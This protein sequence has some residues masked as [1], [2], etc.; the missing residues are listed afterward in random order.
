MDTIGSRARAYRN[1]VVVVVL[2]GFSLLIWAIVAWSISSLS[3]FILLLPVCSFYFLMDDRLLNRWRSCLL[4]DWVAANLELRYFRD[5]INAN[6]L[7]PKET[8]QGMLETL[9]A[10]GDVTDQGIL[11]DTREAI[12]GFVSF[13][14]VCRTDAIAFRTAGYA[15]AGC[16]LVIAAMLHSWRPLL[17]MAALAPVPLIRN[18]VKS[19]RLREAKESFVNKQTKPGFDSEKYL[20]V[21]SQFD[22]S[23]DEQINLME[24]KTG[25]AL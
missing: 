24:M 21:I 20:E 14:H 25:K 11:P 8:L 5:A 16:S 7:L 1:L 6:S 17:G 12:A 18:Y 10:M 19:R 22:L 23:P 13:I 9:P 15:L 2:T 4:T 3:G